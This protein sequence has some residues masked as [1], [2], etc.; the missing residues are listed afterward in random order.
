MTLPSLP[1]D[2]LVLCV[3]P[4]NGRPR[5]ACRAFCAAFDELARE[6]GVDLV[7]RGWRNTSRVVASVVPLE[8]LVLVY[9][10][11]TTLV[12]RFRRARR[13]SW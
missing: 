1:T 4:S 9:L 10:S 2:L 12:A 11:F 13:A 7:L 3:E 5:R 8:S 6:K